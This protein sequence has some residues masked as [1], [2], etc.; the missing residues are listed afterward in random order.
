MGNNCCTST[1]ED[2]AYMSHMLQCFNAPSSLSKTIERRRLFF[3][4]TLLSPGDGKLGH[5]E[6]VTL[7]N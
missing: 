6:T 7:I 2:P 1:S 3:V 5:T 4:F